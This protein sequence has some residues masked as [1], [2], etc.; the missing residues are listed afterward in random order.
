ML[1]NNAKIT[2]RDAKE[3]GMDFSFDKSLMTT[4]IGSVVC[5]TAGVWNPR[6]VLPESILLDISDQGRIF[7]EEEFESNAYYKNIHFDNHKSGCF[8]LTYEVYDEYELFMYIVPLVK[9]GI[10]LPRIAAFDHSFRYPCIKEEGRVWMS[11]APNEILTMKKAVEEA[12]GNVLTLGLGMGYYAYMVAEKDDVEH[13]TIIEKEQD[14]IDLFSNFILPYFSHPEKITVIN[15]DAFEYLK[16]L[17]DGEF[18]YCFADI[19]IGCLDVEPYLNIKK[20]CK[21]FKCMKVEYWIEDALIATT[22]QYVFCAIILQF[23]GNQGEAQDDLS[24]ASEDV[25]AI[26]HIQSVLKDVEISKPEHIDYYMSF[27]N[28]VEL[29]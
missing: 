2:Q 21:R 17:D 10:F 13:V 8:E 25:K 26:K 24:M 14:V 19:W 5:N 16:S 29:L 12:K 20:L 6:D 18:D 3:R 11:V 22:I 28:I 1:E 23:Y 7:H 4:L 15:E 9:E 27:K